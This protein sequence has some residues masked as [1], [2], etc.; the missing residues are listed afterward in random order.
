MESIGEEAHRMATETGGRIRSDELRSCVR[1]RDGELTPPER[2]STTIQGDHFRNAFDEDGIQA[3]SGGKM[4]SSVQSK[5]IRA[6]RNCEGT[7]SR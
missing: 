1:S 5:A 6:L 2:D 3:M 7:W 4:T